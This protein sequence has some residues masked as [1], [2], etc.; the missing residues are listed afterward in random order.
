MPKVEKAEQEEH[1]LCWL[2]YN[3]TPTFL[4]CEF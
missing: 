4:A 1:L 2:Q 3:F